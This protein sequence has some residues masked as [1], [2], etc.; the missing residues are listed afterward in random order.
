MGC[1]SSTGDSE[2]REESKEETALPTKKKGKKQVKI[3]LLG[4]GQSG[5]TTIGKQL[6]ILHQNG[7]TPEE[8]MHY[9][10]LIY[11]NIL[12]ECILISDYCSHMNLEISSESK[13]LL[14]EIED[15]NLSQISPSD[16]DAIKGLWNESSIQD[17]LEKKVEFQLNDSAQFFF[18]NLDRIMA[19]N[20]VPDY[21]DILRARQ[22][23]TGVQCIEFVL[24]GY[25]FVILD[26][27][28]QRSQ[29]HDWSSFFEGLD[30][31]IFVVAISEYDMV[32]AE[33]RTT[34]RMHE[35]LQVFRELCESEVLQGAAVILF[36]NKRDIFA[37]K[38]KRTPLTVCFADY[39]GAN[40]YKPTS[41]Y[42]RNQF[43]G[44]KLK[45]KRK[46]Y[47]HITCATDTN[48]VKR[49]FESVKDFM[50]SKILSDVGFV[51][52]FKNLIGVLKIQ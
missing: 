48:N 11:K 35:S 22:M 16:F 33:D 37:K 38:I 15:G 14:Q 3:L 40:D 8:I 17:A 18:E 46:I 1:T 30:A 20:Y 13:N 23:T 9:R 26:A 36:L 47:P 49:V 42:I 51:W 12:D 25:Q 50:V 32:L 31:F 41:Q 7:F 39:K 28:G 44:M 27:G 45:R 21:S 5:K 10:D 43:V 29:R 52:S 19:P 6:K 4:T 34:N 2:T 24:D